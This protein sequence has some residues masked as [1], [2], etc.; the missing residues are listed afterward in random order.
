MMIP[1]VMRGPLARSQG[2]WS[3]SLPMSVALRKASAPAAPHSAR[4]AETKNAVGTYG[5]PASRRDDCR[6]ANISVIGAAVGNIIAAIIATHM[7]MKSGMS[8]P[9]VSTDAV[10]PLVDGLGPE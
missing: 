5:L 9:I 6:R 2:D 8:M 3:A 4:Y 7:A 10:P 1:P